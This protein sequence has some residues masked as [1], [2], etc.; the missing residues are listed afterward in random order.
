MT[1][2]NLGDLLEGAGLPDTRAN[3][4][5]K[6]LGEMHSAFAECDNRNRALVC[7]HFPFMAQSAKFYGANQHM[8][9]DFADSDISLP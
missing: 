5:V 8:C 6:A 9:N 2:A 1:N 4:F 7:K 3:A